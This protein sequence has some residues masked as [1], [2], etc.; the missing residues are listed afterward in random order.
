MIVFFGCLTA[1]FTWLLCM[2]VMGAIAA[3]GLLLT[4]AVMTVFLV[5]VRRIPREARKRGVKQ[6]LLAGLVAGLAVLAYTRHQEQLQE[7]LDLLQILFGMSVLMLPLFLLA[8]LA[9][10]HI[11][12]WI[13]SEEAHA[14]RHHN[15]AARLLTAIVALALLLFMLPMC[16]P[17]TLSM[18][19]AHRTAIKNRGRGIWIAI[20]SGSMERELFGLPPLWPRDLGFSGNESSTDYFRRL[21]SNEAG[22]V[23]DNQEEALAPDLCHSY[24]CGPGLREATSARAFAAENNAWQVVCVDS[25]TPAW[26]PF[27]ISRNADFGDWLT[28]TS[29]VRLIRSGPLK[30]RRVLWVTQGGGIYDARFNLFNVGMLFPPEERGPGLATTSMVY[31]IMRP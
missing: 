26:V 20:V 10:T 31:R 6:G 28:P 13:G 15:Q 25:N 23:T 12:T 18:D 4:M 24:L 7:A 19:Q 27:L 11:V 3:T 30:L 9:S 1:A 2:V 8:W 14:S 22:E 21:M 17:P 16:S 29:R 5:W